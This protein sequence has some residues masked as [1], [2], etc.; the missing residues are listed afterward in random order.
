MHWDVYRVWI[1]NTKKKKKRLISAFNF[2]LL[3]IKVSSRCE[4]PK[5]AASLSQCVKRANEVLLNRLKTL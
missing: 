5:L 4:N 3:H 2:K 1:V